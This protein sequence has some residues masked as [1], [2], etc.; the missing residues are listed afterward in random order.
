MSTR[1]NAK[2]RKMQRSFLQNAT[3]ISNGALFGA[4]PAVMQRR[5]RNNFAIVI[6]PRAAASNCNARALRTTKFV[7][8][9]NRTDANSMLQQNE[10]AATLAPAMVQNNSILTHRPANMRGPAAEPPRQRLHWRTRA[11]NGPNRRAS[12]YPTRL[13]KTKSAR[14]TVRRTCAV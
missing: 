3:L 4:L 7:P 5:G 10:I 13:L 12:G 14:K 9:D 8:T 11:A 1:C 6:A 2:Q